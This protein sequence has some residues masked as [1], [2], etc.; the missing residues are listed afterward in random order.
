MTRDKPSMVSIINSTGGSLSSTGETVWSPLKLGYKSAR[1]IEAGMLIRI[2]KRMN[3]LDNNPFGDS[4][5][6]LILDTAPYW[7]EGNKT[8]IMTELAGGGATSNGYYPPSVFQE[9]GMRFFPA[10]CEG[11]PVTLVVWGWDDGWEELSA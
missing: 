10:L 5:I 9:G 3:R 6:L 2:T 1:D 11:N 4:P 8:T 7:S